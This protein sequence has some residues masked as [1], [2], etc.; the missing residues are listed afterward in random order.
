MT[1]TRCGPA[2]GLEEDLVV[3]D[4]QVLP[5]DQLDAHV[6]GQEAVLEV[7]R[8]VRPGRQQHDA[9]AGRRPPAGATELRASRS[10]CG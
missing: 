4:E 1:S 10:C 8:V 3:V 2:R 5:E 9:W 7:G 6:A